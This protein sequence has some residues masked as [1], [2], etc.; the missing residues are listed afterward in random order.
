MRGDLR[1]CLRI[2]FLLLL[3]HNRFG[4]LLGASN[5][6]QQINNIQPTLQTLQ[7]FQQQFIGLTMLLV[8][9]GNF[10]QGQQGR[11]G[12]ALLNIN[13]RLGQTH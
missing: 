3:R 13:T 1:K 4:H 2:G 6:L 8:L 5:I 10:L 11:F 12:I 7:Q 9:A